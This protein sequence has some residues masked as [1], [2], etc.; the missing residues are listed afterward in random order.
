M[1]QEW[2][3]TDCLA[4]SQ[5]VFTV[6]QEPVGHRS[7]SSPLMRFFMRISV[8]SGPT[9]GHTES[10]VL[11]VASPQVVASGPTAMDACINPK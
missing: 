10:A 2:C 5:G 7:H 3:V 11:C 6:V 1:Q 9:V 8:P 4:G